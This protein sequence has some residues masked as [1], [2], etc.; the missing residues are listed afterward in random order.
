VFVEDEDVSISLSDTSLSLSVG[1]TSS[2]SAY[3]SPDGASVTWSTSNSS[4][5]TVSGGKVTAAGEGSTTITATATKGSKSAS[6][7]CQ[8]TVSKMESTLCFYSMKIPS[9]SIYFGSTTVSGAVASNYALTSVSV[10]IDDVNTSTLG[11]KI[12]DPNGARMYSFTDAICDLMGYV[13]YPGTFRFRIIA[14][15]ASGKEIEYSS[16]FTISS[17]SA[18]ST[19][20]AVVVNTNGKYLAI[21]DAP[22]ASP[23]KSNQV[24]R[25][26][27]G[28]QVTVYPD[29]T[30]GN[31]YWVEYNGVSGYAYSGY[32]SLQ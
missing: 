29:K 10:C 1:D 4:V 31:W 3:A 21:N 23:D 24:G 12:C 13:T 9:G 22:A 5:A 27:P 30:S 18:T 19:K 15:D 20:T 26:P 32:L 17:A 8:V 28:G 6:A 2:L 11:M 14:K 7:T 16:T 25:I